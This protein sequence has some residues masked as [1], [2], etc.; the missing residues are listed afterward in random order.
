MTCWA[1]KKIYAENSALFQWNSN[2]IM[3]HCESRYQLDVWR[4]RMEFLAAAVLLKNTNHSN[5]T[6]PHHGEFRF[7]RVTQHCDYWVDWNFPFFLIEHPQKSHSIRRRLTIGVF[8]PLHAN[9]SSLIICAEITDFFSS[10]VSARAFLANMGMSL[11]RLE[12]N[13][14]IRWLNVWRENSWPVLTDLIFWQRTLARLYSQAFALLARHFLLLKTV[15]LYWQI[16]PNG[17]LSNVQ[18]C[19]FVKVNLY[20]STT[21]HDFLRHSLSCT[22]CSSGWISIA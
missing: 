17:K 7:H 19:S 14:H 15:T 22:R 20:L 5:A 9:L 21:N 18:K 1:V 16:C 13:S 6:T 11:P 10:S 4:L 3:T 8:A 12:Q 2:E